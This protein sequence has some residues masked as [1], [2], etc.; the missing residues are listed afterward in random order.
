MVCVCNFTPVQYDD[1]RIGLPKPG[2]LREALS[3]DDVAFGGTGVHGE[4]EIHAVK[5]PF[6]DLPYSALVTL[7]PMSC[8]YYT[9]TS[10]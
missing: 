9:Y 4:A 3:S 10:K 5:E 8:V 7:P 1:F 6:C 2:V